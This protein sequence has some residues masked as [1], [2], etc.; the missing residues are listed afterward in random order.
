MCRIDNNRSLQNILGSMNALFF[1]TVVI[2]REIASFFTN[3]LREY[4]TTFK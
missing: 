4:M 3:S 2:P 1:D